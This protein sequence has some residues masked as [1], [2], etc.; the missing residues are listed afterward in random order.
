M[1]RQRARMVALSLCAADVPVLAAAFLLAYWVREA[2]LFAGEGALPPLAKY[3]WLLL[4]IV[5]VWSGLLAY[6]GLYGSYRTKPLWAEPAA[7]ARVALWATLLTG[8]V[9]FA[10]K[11]TFVSRLFIGL[12]GAVAFTL[13]SAHRVALRTLAR[14]VWRS[15]YNSRNVLIVGSGRRAAEIARILEDHK[16]W[17]LKVVGAVTDFESV[18]SQRWDAVPELGHVR[19]LPN[20]LKQQV[21]DEVIFAVSRQKLEEMENIFLVCEELGIRAHVAVNF[22]PHTIAK[23]HLDA[24]HGIPLLTFSTTPYNEFLLALKRA[25]DLAA[26]GTLL[27]ALAP[28]FLLIAV[29]IKLTSPGPVLFRQTRVGLNGR[30]FTL[31]KFRSMVQDAEA[32]K[33]ELVH[34][35]EMAGPVFK[36]RNDP[37]VTPVGRLLR[38]TSLDEL[39]Q[40][41]NVL[42][43]DMSLVGPRPPV[44][45]EVSAYEPWQRRRL[46]MKPGLTCLWQ[47]NGRNGIVDFEKWM[48]LDLQY[49]DNWSLKLDFQ[50]FVKTIPAVLLG[51]GAA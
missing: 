48:A 27:V 44:P 13:L 11:M 17:G 33:Q 32:R 4:A 34:L 9:T 35:N 1:L 26:S 5:P 41:F 50:I 20:I 24:L 40:L 46:S 12:F 3:G 28:L 14:R 42:K 45:E 51:K 22:F 47:I 19:E 25:F 43:G 31:Y 2:P 10:L 8:T 21:V 16:H 29:A 49:I 7:L 15:G 30:R 18:P 39:P 6:F 38:R 23:L 37:R 36:I